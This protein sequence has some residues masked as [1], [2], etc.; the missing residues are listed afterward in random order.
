MTTFR[1]GQSAAP[2]P[3]VQSCAH[4]ARRSSCYLVLP[5]LCYLTSRFAR[6]SQV[7]DAHS[8]GQSLCVEYNAGVRQSRRPWGYINADTIHDII[9]LEADG[10]QEEKV[11]HSGTPI[12]NL[13]IS[14]APRVQCFRWDSGNW[15][16]VREG[17]GLPHVSGSSSLQAWVERVWFCYAA[18]RRREKEQERRT[19][20]DGYILCVVGVSRAKVERGS[21]YL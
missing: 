17:P 3:T 9:A 15:V 12:S 4:V 2:F 19:W 13:V 18:I 10:S 16:C 21:S 6:E 5:C 14:D 7:P 8:S 11:E 1:D 20:R